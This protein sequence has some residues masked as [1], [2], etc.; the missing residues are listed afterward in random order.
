M[1]PEV[2]LLETGEARPSSPLT[3]NSQAL[4]ILIFMFIKGGSPYG[5]VSVIS[6]NFNSILCFSTAIIPQGL[7][8]IGPS[9][10]SSKPPTHSGEPQTPHIR[11]LLSLSGY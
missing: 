5:E 8:F 6:W 3:C 4:N 2:Y 1:P 10:L 9:S 7:V 11:R